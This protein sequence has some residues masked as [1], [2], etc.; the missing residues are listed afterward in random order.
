MLEPSRRDETLAQTLSFLWSLSSAP[1][2]RFSALWL[3][4]RGYSATAVGASGT[5]VVF[6]GGQGRGR[7]FNDCH[8]LA[9][10]EYLA[11]ETKKES[12]C[13]EI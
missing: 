1:W 3:L 6:F 7:W 8:L 9:T 4:S 13:I 10:T 2:N 11:P 12:L 5:H